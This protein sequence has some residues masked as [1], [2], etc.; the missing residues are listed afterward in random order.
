M[1]PPPIPSAAQRLL[2]PDARSSREPSR[3]PSL[4]PS[5]ALTEETIM[6]EIPS[7][8]GHIDRAEHDIRMRRVRKRVEGSIAERDQSIAE[9]DQSIAERNAAIEQQWE[10]FAQHEAKIAELMAVL[11]LE[12]NGH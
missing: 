4:A 8:A 11:R 9:R 1:A 2:P 7:Y 3:E 12:N 10:M 5:L 6:E